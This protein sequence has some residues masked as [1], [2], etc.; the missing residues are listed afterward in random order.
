MYLKDKRMLDIIF[1]RKNFSKIKDYLKNDIYLHIELQITALLLN[2]NR[3]IHSLL[4]SLIDLEH[5]FIFDYIEYECSEDLKERIIGIFLEF[6]E[7][8]I[9]NLI[10]YVTK[11]ETFWNLYFILFILLQKKD[12]RIF[13]FI[14]HLIDLN[15]FTDTQTIGEVFNKIKTINSS[16]FKIVLEKMMRNEMNLGLKNFFEKYH[17]EL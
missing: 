5:L 13:D 16:K 10:D 17:N 14:N 4:D 7:Q 6:D 12:H 3:F 15:I 8:T 1:N 2:P 9:S 11:N